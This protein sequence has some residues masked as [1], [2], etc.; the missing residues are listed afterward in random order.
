MHVC[1]DDGEVASG[2]DAFI[3][4]W[5]RLPRFRWLAVL[6]A[7]PGPRQLFSAAYEWIAVPTLAAWNARRERRSQTQ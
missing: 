1:N 7:L 4:V 2:V 3:A 6:V 5:R